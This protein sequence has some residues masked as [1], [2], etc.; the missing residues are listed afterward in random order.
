IFYGSLER[1]LG[2]PFRA[3]VVHRLLIVAALD[4]LVLAVLRRLLPN[5]LAWL[6]AAW[7]ALLPIDF[8]SLYEVHLF[9]ALPALLALAIVARAADA[10]GRA[11]ALG[12][13]VASAL[14]VRNEHLIA[15]GL[16]AAV[17]LTLE[18]RRPPAARL[19]A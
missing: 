11:A 4:V 9:S 8:D 13:L 7:L 1:V 16:W 19:A 10:R 3:T 17:C 18:A 15:A 6:L 5:G 2:D 12:I 14:L